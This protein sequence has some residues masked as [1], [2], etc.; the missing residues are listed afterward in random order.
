ME[1][2]IQI[3]PGITLRC[4][5]VNHFKQGCVS[6]QF[7]RQMRREEAAMNALLPA[8]LLRGCRRYPDLRAITARLDELY[9]AAVGATVRRV[10]DYQTTGL[11]CGFMEDRFALEGD[12]VLEP[13]IDFLRQLLLEPVLEDGVFRADFVQSEKRNLIAAMESERN[14]K[15]VYANAQLIRRMCKADSFGIP[16][17]GEPE[18]VAV[19][20]SQGLYAHY[21]R[22][23]K[24][25]PV[26]IIYVGSGA[27]EEIARLFRELFHG[28]DRS[29]VNLPA[30]TSFA[31]REGGDYREQME[32]SQ[33]KLCVGFVTP[34]TIR[35]PQYPAMLMAN[36]IFG[37]GMISKLFMQVREKLSLCYDIG[38][39]Y[40]GS[41]GILTVSAGI[42][43]DK[44]PLV[45][46]QV[47]ELLEE[48]C[49]GVI[50]RQEMEAARQ[51]LLSSLRATYDS[52]GAIEG[53]H[54]SAAL[55]GFPMTVEQ[56]RRALEEVTE[57][58][59]AQ[60]AKSLTLH[61][62]YFLEGVA[63]V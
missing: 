9:G 10:G 36:H 13:M 31:D 49:R 63:Q 42:D 58:Q 32:V 8:V 38:S 27:P 48:L 59:V 6:I 12:K 19:I 23:L 17:L 53:Y 14:D 55:S 16:R 43:F 11:S 21:R 50:S 54:A 34:I 52:P 40:H 62:V 5:P 39:G 37:G 22:V 35:D 41:K 7:L 18:Q 15:R 24:E 28:V 30:Q 33:G 45:R 29:Y 60:A 25:S 2:T 57:G 3:L 61:S 1:K 47:L 51:S 44:E 46:R 26:Q 56:Y 4:F 20:T